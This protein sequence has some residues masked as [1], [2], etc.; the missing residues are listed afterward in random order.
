MSAG[1]RLVFAVQAFVGPI[2]VV[3]GAVGGL[4]YGYSRARRGDE[5]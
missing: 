4:V 3:V 2:G 1:A 5:R